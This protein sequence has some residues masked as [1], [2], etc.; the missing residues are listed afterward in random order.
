MNNQTARSALLMCSS[1]GLGLGTAV[2]LAKRGYALAL[3]GRDMGSLESAIGQCRKENPNGQ[4]YGIVADVSTVEG[5]RG[6]VAKAVQSLGRLDMLLLNSPGPTPGRVLDM[7]MSDWQS[8]YESLVLAP[9]QVMND[10]I[11][12]LKKSGSGRVV[13]VSSVSA[14]KPIGNLAL[15]N[16]LRPAVE[17]YVKNLALE[18]SE[19]KITAN[20]L[21]PGRILSDRIHKLVDINAKKK[22]ATMEQ[23]LV[24][25]SSDIP[26]KRLGD[27]H[28]FGELVAFLASPEAAYVTGQVIGVDGGLS[29]V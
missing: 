17:G 13:A 28:E 27:I 29:V 9:M 16:V 23:E 20:V 25:Y 22:N 12:E 26:L 7:K 6:L 24:S 18:L 8:A 10:A 19:A 21:R 2:A 11:P 14:L 5:A 3:T 4:F 1:K 15:S